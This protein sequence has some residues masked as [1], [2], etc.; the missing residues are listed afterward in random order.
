[1][2]N[3]KAQRILSAVAKDTGYTPSMLRGRKRFR[4]ITRA[5][6]IATFLLQ[7]RLGMSL[8]AIAAELGGRDHATVLHAIRNVRRRLEAKDLELAD[9]LVRID[10]AIAGTAAT[11]VKQTTLPPL[12][13]PN[14]GFVVEVEGSRLGFFKRVRVLGVNNDGST[15]VE[16]KSTL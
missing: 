2:R 3:V 12:P 14:A 15:V 9:R 11:P 4:L 13:A 16:W 8:T 10:L 1:M 7:E 5:R 6:D